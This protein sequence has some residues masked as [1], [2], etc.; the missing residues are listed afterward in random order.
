MKDSLLEAVESFGASLVQ[1]QSLF[2]SRFVAQ[3]SSEPAHSQLSSCHVDRKYTSLG[4]GVQQ[5]SVL[6]ASVVSVG[7]KVKA[8]KG[9]LRWG[10]LG[11]SPARHASHPLPEVSVA[12]LSF[13]LLRK[14]EWMKIWVIAPQA[15]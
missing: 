10:F 3:M 2:V 14:M 11:L 5:S 1:Y 7:E 8:D 6:Q 4:Q 12:T 13:W 9:F 15:L